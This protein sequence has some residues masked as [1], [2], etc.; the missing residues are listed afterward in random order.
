MWKAS[1]EAFCFVRKSNGC[2]SMS[3]LLN[4]LASD[5]LAWMRQKPDNG[6]NDALLWLDPHRDFARLILHLGPVLEREGATLLTLA[7]E[8][9]E[10]ESSRHG[11]AAC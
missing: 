2:T 8:Q 4:L 6:R 9:G 7:P 3:N 11:N 5:L 1:F 10:G